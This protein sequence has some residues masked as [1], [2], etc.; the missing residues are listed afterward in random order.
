MLPREFWNLWIGAIPFGT[1]AL[2]AFDFDDMTAL[3][4]ITNAS[5]GQLRLPE[6]N[7]CRRREE[8]CTR[9]H[10]SNT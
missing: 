2:G 7:L 1:V 3:L 5:P 4:R 6:G 9:Y 8:S 10:D